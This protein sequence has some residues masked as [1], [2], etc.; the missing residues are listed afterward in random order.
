MVHLFPILTL[1]LTPT[2]IISIQ[3]HF[4]IQTTNHKLILTHGTHPN[5]ETHD[6]KIED[7]LL[8]KEWIF[9][10]TSFNKT[11]PTLE[12]E[13]FR[14]E[15]FFENR[16][17]ITKFNQD[18][19]FGHSKFVLQIN[20]TADLLT[21]EYNDVYNGYGRP[22]KRNGGHK[23]NPTTYIPSLNVLLPENFDW[24]DLGGVTSVKNQG[25][26]GG[27]FAFSATGAL[28]GHHFRKAGYL[29]ELSPQNLIDCTREYSNLGCSG[30]YVDESFNYIKDNPGIDVLSAYPYEGEE[31]SCRFD[32]N[33]I[34]AN[35]TGYV[36][37]PPGDER[38]LATAVATQGPVSVAIDASQS[39]FQF[40]SNGIY[41]DEEC[42]NDADSLNHA[43]L[44]VGY[45]SEPDGTKYWLVKNSYGTEWGLGGYIKMARDNDNHCGIATAAYYPLV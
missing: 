27:C 11:Y 2:P 17:K 14:K 22:A 36:E 6:R 32:P 39:T 3:R 28:E 9:F 12:D 5:L 40:Y 25:K 45:G 21:H 8:L 19:S 41:Y 31:G 30:G 24:K 7:T 23:D 4:N 37:I 26:C 43:V 42:K 10:K 20:P 35:V 16:K 33:F 13:N 38:A 15:V 44:V 29:E 34:G 1:L 18:Y